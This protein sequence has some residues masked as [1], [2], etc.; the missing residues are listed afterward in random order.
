MSQE[1][2]ETTRFILRWLWLSAQ[3]LLP[4]HCVDAVIFHFNS[5]SPFN[6]DLN[7]GVP[8]QVPCG[9]PLPPSQMSCGW[10]A[11]CSPWSCDTLSPP[12]FRAPRWLPPL[13]RCSPPRRPRWPRPR[14]FGS[15]GDAGGGCLCGGYSRPDS[16]WPRRTAIRPALSTPGYWPTPSRS[17]QRRHHHHLL[18][19]DHTYK[20]KLMRIVMGCAS[21]WID[22]INKQQR[23]TADMS[24]VS[25]VYR[26]KS[27]TWTQHNVLS[28]FC[29]WVRGDDSPLHQVTLVCIR[30][31]WRETGAFRKADLQT[32]LW[33]IFVRKQNNWA[34]TD[35][36]WDQQHKQQRKWA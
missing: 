36:Q 27:S 33:H 13:Q 7:V 12:C 9:T 21:F 18:E 34:L 10:A 30:H 35:S 11:A 28:T 4:I 25:P 8:E 19:N 31:S 5:C 15:L 32:A 29:T 20:N 3:N 1:V 6:V 14:C 23:T 24:V 17:L 2:I 26:P 16:R 22:C